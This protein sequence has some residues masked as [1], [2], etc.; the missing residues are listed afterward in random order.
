MALEER[1]A[2]AWPPFGRLVLLR[3]DSHQRE[4]AERFLLA[5]ARMAQANPVASQLTILGPAPAIMERRAGRYRHQLILL[6]SERT[7]LDALFKDW[8]TALSH[9]PEAKQV[10]YALDVDPVEL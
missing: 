2:A 5:A 7:A 4:A 8:L 9:L 3:A 10:R 1:R 6:A